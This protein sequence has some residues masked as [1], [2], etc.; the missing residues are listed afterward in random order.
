MAD[1]ALRVAVVGRSVYSLHGYGGLERH[2]YDLVRYHLADGWYVTLIT[3]T[4][5]RTEG[6][7]PA[8]WR[9]IAE[10]PRCT[11]RYVP[12][13]TFPLAG[14][15]GTTII[16][17]STAYPW[18]GARAGDAAL[19]LVQAGHIDLVY[20]VGASVYGYA[21]ARAAHAASAPLVFNPQGLEEFGGVD[22]RYGGQRL[23]ALAYLPLR[24]VVRKTAAAADAVIATDAAIEPAVLAHLP[25]P[26]GRVHV[27]P[28]GLD[29]I[30]GDR[31][32]SRE[33]GIMQRIKHHVG[34]DD[35]L[36][37]SV[38]RL[39]AN[40]GFTDLADALAGLQLS[41]AWR[42]VVAG[43]GPLRSALEQRIAARGLS[44]RTILAG[45]PDDA[46][47]HAWYDAADLFVHPTRYEGSSLVT[48]EAMLHAKPVV[49]S[50]AGGLP[51]KV[52]AGQTGWLV[53]ASDPFALGAAVSDAVMQRA[54]WPE[55]GR[56]GRAL[57]EQ[58]FDWRVIQGKFRELY[59]ALLTISAPP[60]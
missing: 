37:L 18:F 34:K 58:R 48:L 35:V 26:H 30:D 43:D 1:R 33:A 16:D 36:L 53:P 3:R 25:V 27:V 59:E 24:R 9:E 19:R 13:H 52:I 29:V 46:S 45:R 55:M 51:D 40:K 54:R 42:W 38:G 60:A 32:V 15:R 22:G 50:R 7:D 23:K 20:G 49:A 11:V 31:L 28:N 6:V 8:R 41:T 14:R 44:G 39:E 21:R 12:Y 2:L 57:L 10:H 17:R 5:E 56:A 4:P 47:L